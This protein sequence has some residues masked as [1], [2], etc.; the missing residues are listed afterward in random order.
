MSSR[1]DKGREGWVGEIF[2]ERFRIEAERD[3]SSEGWVGE[4]LS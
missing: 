3:R 2:S 1:V 4:I